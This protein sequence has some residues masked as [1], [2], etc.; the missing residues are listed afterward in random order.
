M[1]LRARS[2]RRACSAAIAS[3]ALVSVCSTAFAQ[4][5]NQFIGFG[6]STIDSGWFLTHRISNDASL[7]SLY[8]A[9]AAV[10]GG[11]P[12]GPGGPMNSQVLAS[13][14]GLTAIPVGEPGGTNFAA[15][16]ATNITYADDNS[17][18][19]TTRESDYRLSG[20]QRRRQSQRALYDQ[21]RRER[22]L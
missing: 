7:E 13:L 16:G 18:A 11:I 22:H 1:H 21:L 19:L 12:T 10:G 2:R 4:S 17:L 6:D 5:F 14:F 20:S 9:S 8:R 3:V 15:G